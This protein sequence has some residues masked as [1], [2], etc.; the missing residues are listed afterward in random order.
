MYRSDVVNYIKEDLLQSP[1]VEYTWVN[2]ICNLALVDEQMYKKL[3]H[4]ME[5]MDS[6]KKLKLY[7]EMKLFYV[8]Y[9]S[10]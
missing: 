5:E 1:E 7:K 10:M 4:Y 9:F 6:S 8:D 3:S 2:K